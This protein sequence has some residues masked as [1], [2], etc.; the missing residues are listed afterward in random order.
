MFHPMRP[1]LRKLGR[2]WRLLFRS[3]RPAD[4]EPT[5]PQD[6]L[7]RPSPRRPNKWAG[8]AAFGRSSLL[9]LDE[10]SRLFQFLLGGRWVR[11]K[12]AAPMGALLRRHGLC[13][14]CIGAYAAGLWVSLSGGSDLAPDRYAA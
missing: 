14:R 9:D 10:A 1:I 11:R 5:P 4:A 2:C 12:E 13:S 6:A 3:V 8:E 7:Y